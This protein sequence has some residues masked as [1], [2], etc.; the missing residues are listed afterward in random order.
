MSG[1]WFPQVPLGPRSPTPL[2]RTRIRALSQDHKHNFSAGLS[3]RPKTRRSTSKC[4]MAAV[5][6][7]IPHCCVVEVDKRA[8]THRKE[9][10]ECASMRKVNKISIRLRSSP[11]SSMLVYMPDYRAPR[12]RV[13]ARA[14]DGQ[15]RHRTGG[16]APAQRGFPRTRAYTIDE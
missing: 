10:R 3:P 14:L 4:A 11:L 2:K 15:R 5:M 12:V 7:A 16:H 1:N 6:K 8:R 9:K 13:S